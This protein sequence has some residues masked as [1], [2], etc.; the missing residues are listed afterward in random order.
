V[1][2]FEEMV[3]L[4]QQA[5]ELARRTGNRVQELTWMTGSLLALI[6]VGRLDQALASGAAARS[7]EELPS[8]QWVSSGLAD[9]VPLYVIRGDLDEAR[10]LLDSLQEM[11]TSENTETRVAYAVA[12]AELLR[13]EGK[14]A[15]GLAAL[16]EVLAARTHFGLA[17][18]PIKRGLV[19]G[20]EAALDLGDSVK[21]EEI[22][23]IVGAARPG[24]VTPYLRAHAARLAARLA[25]LRGEGESVEP[26][27]VAAAQGF[28]DL[29]T[30]FDLALSLLEHAQWL[31]DEGRHVQAEPL[32]AE[33]REIFERLGAIPWLERTTRL[34]VSGR[35]SAPVGE[36]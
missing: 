18:H 10:G 28:R 3:E 9:L 13:A 26:G 27:F 8:L 14:P 11:S 5:L 33:A 12:R 21:A 29:G 25:A 19:Q 1:D 23:G 6:H 2:R 20:L 7:A 17:H 34:A 24:Q 32:L 16:E 30:P 36:P 35:A 22:L 15:D 31:S 4:A